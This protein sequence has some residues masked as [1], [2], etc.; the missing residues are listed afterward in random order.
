MSAM[1]QTARRELVLRMAARYQ[2]ATG[3]DKSRVLDEF[4]HATGFHRKYAI[5]QLNSPPDT[6]RAVRR[7]RARRYGQAA[8][9]ALIVA[10]AAAN[11]I[12]SKRLTP[13]LPD[14]L[15]ILERH[16]HLVLTD[17][18]RGELLS[19]SAAT[20]DRIL[21]PARKSPRAL[22]LTHSGAMLKRHIPVRTF[23]EWEDV[24]PGFFE[25]DLVCHCGDSSRGRFL[26]T[27][28]LT[29]IATGWVELVALE[30]KSSTGVVEGLQEIQAVLPFKLLGLDVDNGAEFINDDVADHL[31]RQAVTFTRGRAYRKNDQ[32]YV[33]Q[34]NGSVVRRTTGHARYEGPEAQAQMAEL[35]R[36]LRLYV[37][38]FQPSMK[39]VSKARENGKSTRRYSL[40]RTPLQRCLDADA[41]SEE[42]KAYWVH[43]SQTVDPVALRHELVKLQAG[44]ELH[45]CLRVGGAPD[46]P[47]VASELVLPAALRTAERENA[48]PATAKSIRPYGRFDTVRRELYDWF[49]A[50]SGIVPSKLMRRLQEA[51][52][53]QFPDEW[54]KALAELLAGWRKA[55][56]VF[57]KT[58][59]RGRKHA[60]YEDE[61]ELR[62]LFAQ[63]PTVSSS[64]ML[65]RLQR[66]CPGKYTRAN[67]PALN[68]LLK[69]WRAQLRQ[70]DGDE[71]G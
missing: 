28:T 50:D 2:E 44:M 59:R 1:S 63:E 10:W 17:E 60:F 55:P 20:V 32:C 27:L 61:A 57:A 25:G 24:R 48:P 36:L 23:A 70:G 5:S 14:L 58:G 22:S 18:V 34:K 9:E 3:E 54:T 12:C 11:Y 37:N 42:Q 47:L 69:R 21:A 26:C 8:Q 41:L 56:E 43:V 13:Y 35:Y 15:P 33:E 38:V 4:V 29:D 30:R 46:V 62:R 40:A 31:A 68:S 67:Q 45:A 65:I 6:S 39:L 51:Y 19:M 53:Q 64:S 7:P 49:L 71:L 16:G 66:Q 52:P